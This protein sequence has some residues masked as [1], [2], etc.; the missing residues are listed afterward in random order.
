MHLFKARNYTLHILILLFVFTTVKA[1]T[2]AEDNYF[3]GVNRL[4]FGN[5]LFSEKDYLRAIDEFR[6]YLKTENNDTIQF[7]V[8]ESFLRINRFKEAA[9]NFKSLFFHSPLSDEAR[10]G[11]YKSLFF[12]KDFP[13]LKE[14]ADNMDYLPESF[15]EEIQRLRY[16]SYF[17]DNSTLPDT[18]KFIQLFPDSSHADI[19][20]FYLMKNYPPKKNPTKA[21]LLSAVVPGLGKIYSEQIGDGITAFIT[22]GLLTFLSV[23]NFNHDHNF[24]GWLF[25]GMAAFSYAG[26][27]YGSAASAHVYNAGVKL[28]FDKEIKLYFEKRNYFLPNND[29]LK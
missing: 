13:L 3:S 14:Y 2:T 29:W 12:Q 17:S 6:E 18:N 16:I 10:L 28:S 8:A 7:K 19:Y 4:K 5:Y 22:T 23:N 27:I 21:A 25:A 1:Q 24:R 15:G 11:F 20:K 9:E 26:N